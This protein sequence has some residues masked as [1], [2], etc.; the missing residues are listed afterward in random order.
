M[1]SLI[2]VHLWREFP[3]LPRAS[4]F[5][6]LPLESCHSKGAQTWLCYLR[7]LA[8]KI[9]ADLVGDGNL[10]I[11]SVNTLEEAKPGQISFLANPKYIKQLETDQRVGGHR[12]ARRQARAHPP[13]QKQ[14][15]LLHLLAGGRDPARLSEASA[16]RHLAGRAYRSDRNDRRRNH[17]LPRRL[18]RSA[19]KVGRDCVLHANVVIYEDCI[20][21]DRVII[22]ANSS[23]G[24]DG[25]GFATLNGIQHKIPQVGK[26]IIED[27]VEVGATPPLIAAAL[28][29]TVIGKGSKVGNL[30]AIGH[31]VHIGEHSLI[32]AQ[33]GI[34]G[35]VKIGHHCTMAGQVGVAGHLKIGN[36]VTLA[37]DRRHRRHPRPVHLHRR[38]AMP[39]QQA[40]RV[41]SLFTHLP[42]LLQRIKQ[43][44]QKVEEL[45]S[46]ESN[47]AP[48]DKKA[49][50]T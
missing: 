9:G 13:A 25:F 26:V 41:Y 19:T 32:V 1:T 30:N 24:P 4:L 50:A 49:G 10:S 5:R 23:I 14:R 46:E 2:C 38:S 15:A 11:H 17:R 8:I 40:R 35:S 31:N 44:E 6:G 36:N 7:E 45:S 39:A 27:D 48:G 3:P 37:T 18:C 33:V 16:A 12:F 22:N 42:D 43:L 28:G 21:G 29:S 34:A 20:I 47:E